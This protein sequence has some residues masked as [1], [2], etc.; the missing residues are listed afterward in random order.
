MEMEAITH[1]DV[2]RV[3]YRAD[4]LKISPMPVPPRVPAVTSYI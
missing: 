4:G 3:K 2:W 1:H